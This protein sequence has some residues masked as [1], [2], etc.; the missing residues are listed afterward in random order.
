VSIL[1]IGAEGDLGE[2]VVTRLVDQGDEV[3]VI[4]PDGRAAGRWRALGAHVAAG[5]PDDADLVERAAQN[6]RT[7][8]VLND[9]EA[10]PILRGARAAR[11]GRL[12]VCT[13][14]RYRHDL[15]AG[16]F[17]YVVLTVP[18]TR[19][20][21][22]PALSPGALAAAVDAADDLAGRPRMSVDLGDP[23]GWRRLGLDPPA[24]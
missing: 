16:D 11:V 17:E 4:E 18:R 14:A 13:G 5:S 1:L 6:V 19:F 23:S 8:V 9:H 20:G 2:A 21:R 22:R 7:V 3:R 15:A 24:S 10:E 12:V